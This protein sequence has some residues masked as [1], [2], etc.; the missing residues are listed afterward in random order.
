MRLEGL[1]TAAFGKCVGA[2]DGF[3]VLWASS[4]FPEEARRALGDIAKGFGLKG[5]GGDTVYAA[6]YALWPLR[7]SQGWVAARLRDAGKDSFGRPHTLA[8]DAVF[9]PADDVST[10]T[11]FLQPVAWPRGD[12]SERQRLAVSLPPPDDLLLLR[13]R[14]KVDVP[15]R[16]SVLRAFHR[17]YFTSFDVEIDSAGDLVRPHGGQA[18][19]VMPTQ[20]LVGRAS[21]VRSHAVPRRR[22]LQRWGASAIAFCLGA[23]VGFCWHAWSV[24]EM[25][26]LHE[27]ALHK[28]EKERDDELAKVGAAG[29][30]LKD[31]EREISELSS[32]LNEV[33]D[34]LQDARDDAEREE[35]FVRV[36]EEYGVRNTGELRRVLGIGADRQ[37]VDDA[38]AANMWRALDD[39]ESALGDAK[40]LWQK[41]MP[42]EKPVEAPRVPQ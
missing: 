24:S 40:R 9:V 6:C 23:S 7:A 4:G 16:P 10:A 28:I 41:V 34:D 38:P 37:H 13:M 17:S 15:H 3:R 14:E 2:D 27:V 32:Q 18:G 5:D 8:I 26:R 11:G 25:M 19:D 29:R 20:R 42:R 1:P 36:S 39:A 12:W 33:R 30:E 35:S 31:R 22:G 21:D